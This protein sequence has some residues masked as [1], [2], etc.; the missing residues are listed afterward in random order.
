MQ[1][2]SKGKLIIDFN[3]NHSIIF[4]T[5][6]SESEDLYGIMEAYKINSEA[7]DN[8]EFIELKDFK[9]EPNSITEVDVYYY[10]LE[11]DYAIDCSEDYFVVKKREE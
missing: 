8:D 5:D 7:L 10:V 3:N 2:V 1:F 6:L 9:A 11:N 4:D